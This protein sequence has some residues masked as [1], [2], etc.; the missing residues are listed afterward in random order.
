MPRKYRDTLVWSLALRSHRIP[1][2]YL[3]EWKQREKEGSGNR[4]DLE[5]ELRAAAREG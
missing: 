2:Q 1:Q 5:I 3:E 4:E